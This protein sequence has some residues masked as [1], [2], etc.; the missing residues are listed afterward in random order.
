MRK[1]VAAA[2]MIAA[3]LTAY[4]V[5]GIGQDR[6][7]SDSSSQI[8]IHGTPVCVTQRGGG[9]EAAVGECEAVAGRGP[10]SG[11]G[12]FH[13]GNE[14]PGARVPALPPGHPPVGPG[15]DPAGESARR[16]PI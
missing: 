11:H 13:G 16:I 9:I 6:Y 8:F 12:R 2:A 4:S 1:I 5:W 7:A 10:G 15:S 14:A 3:G